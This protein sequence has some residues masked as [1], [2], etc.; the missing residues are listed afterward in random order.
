MLAG[1]S[2]KNPLWLHLYCSCWMRWCGLSSLVLTASDADHSSWLHLKTAHT[3]C[4]DVLDCMQ[5]VALGKYDKAMASVGAVVVVSSL[6]AYCTE[7]FTES[8]HC[9]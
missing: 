4:M 6:C 3:C 8:L 5:D 9:G 2:N 1:F 7:G